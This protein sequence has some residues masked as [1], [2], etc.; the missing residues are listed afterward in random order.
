M[1][2]ADTS[3]LTKYQIGQAIKDAQ[4]VMLKVGGI[5]H[6]AFHE[7]KISKRDARRLLT[8]SPNWDVCY[9]TASQVTSLRA[10]SAEGGGRNLR[11]LPIGS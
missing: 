11:Y 2:V 3:A 1:F 7:V 6:D 10:T 8:E 4:C 5:D 9:R